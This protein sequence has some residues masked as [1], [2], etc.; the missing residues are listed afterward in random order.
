MH[1]I[2]KSKPTKKKKIIKKFNPIIYRNNGKHKVK[3][4]ELGDEFT[5]VEFQY[6]SSYKYLNGGWIQ[7]HKDSFIRDCKTKGKYP[8]LLALNIPIAPEKF[9]FKR[10]GQLHRYTL[11]FPALPKST[12]S[13]DIIEKEAPGTYFNFYDQEFSNWMTV[14]HPADIKMSNN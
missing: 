13:I 9:Y 2:P 1:L 14:E 3:S 5:L 7:I 8:L 11:V 10:S 4:I 12:E 6:R